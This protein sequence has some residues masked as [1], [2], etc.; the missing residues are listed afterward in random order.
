MQG[1]YLK[2]WDCNAGNI[3]QNTNTV[4]YFS[5]WSDVENAIN[6]SNNCAANTAWL[7]MKRYIS[8]GGG[9]PST[10][11]MNGG[12][13][14]RLVDAINQGR[15][16]NYQGICLDIEVGAGNTYGSFSQVI[17]A[18]KNRGMEVLVTTSHS[19]PTDV[20]DSESL[21]NSLIHNGKID[22]LS[23]QLYSNGIF[24]LST[25]EVLNLPCMF[26]II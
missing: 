14:A 9:N 2:T 4:V 11:A 24:L 20:P 8:F 6:E 1:Y 23:P 21:M 5:G 19:A 16:S 17:D 18:A 25:N 12:N 3:P 15:I 26:V 22:Y 10:G 13:L 7:N